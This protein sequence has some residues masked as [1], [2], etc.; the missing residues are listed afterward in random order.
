MNKLFSLTRLWLILLSL[1]IAFL[2]VCSSLPGGNQMMLFKHADK[3]IHFGYFMGISGLIN[4]YWV[5]KN[6]RSYLSFGW[7][8]MIIVAMLG[9]FDE[10]Y[11]S[12]SPGRSGNDLGDWIADCSGGIV[13]YLIIRFAYHYAHQRVSQHLTTKK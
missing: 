1:A 8:S 10:W 9:A 7:L 2:V 4:L 5:S 13:G 6:P 3:V 12:F 11:Q